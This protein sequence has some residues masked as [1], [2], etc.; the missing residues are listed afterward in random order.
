MCKKGNVIHFLFSIGKLIENDAVFVKS[1]L[2][3]QL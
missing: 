2:Q 1:S 3:G